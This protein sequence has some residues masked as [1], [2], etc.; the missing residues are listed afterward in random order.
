MTTDYGS[1]TAIRPMTST[2][3]T[4]SQLVR[5][6]ALTLVTDTW[7][8]RPPMTPAPS[9]G[10]PSLKRRRSSAPPQIQQANTTTTILHTVLLSKLSY[11]LPCS[12][13]TI[14]FPVGILMAQVLLLGGADAVTKGLSWPAVLRNLAAGIENIDNEDSKG[15]A[16]LYAKSVKPWEPSV[17]AGLL[18]EWVAKQSTDHSWGPEPA[19]VSEPAAAKQRV[20]HDFFAP[21]LAS[22]VSTPLPVLV[23][24]N[25]NP[26]NSL[27]LNLSLLSE[28]I[29]SPAF[30]A[31]GGEMDD[32]QP[33]GDF[34]SLLASMQEDQ[35]R[36]AQ[37]PPPVVDWFPRPPR[38]SKDEV[39]LPTPPQDKIAIRRESECSDKVA[40][41]ATYS[42]VSMANSNSPYDHPSSSSSTPSDSTI[43]VSKRQRS[44]HPKHIGL[45]TEPFR[46]PPP[47]C[48]YFHTGFY[49][50]QKDKIGVWRGELGVLNDSF[51]IMVVGE[52]G[53]GKRELWQV[54][55]CRRAPC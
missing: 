33:I 1:T 44:N 21:A 7:Q 50:L 41:T 43:H 10:P 19:P 27:D 53:Q 18:S 6:R 37:A 2:G 30:V 4:D 11:T 49:D 47:M 48:M 34:E 31:P 23:N 52:A 24:A 25:A 36:A 45:P 3:L 55:R 9:S 54:I 32:G 5:R 35:E 14:D 39:Q 29:E 12:Y 8:H 28:H 26:F 13:Q 51:S 40:A 38:P 46:P 15:L 17:F 16:D 22:K 20:T 42:P